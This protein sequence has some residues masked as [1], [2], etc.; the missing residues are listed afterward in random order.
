MSDHQLDALRNKISQS[1]II[2]EEIFELYK[3]ITRNEAFVQIEQQLYEVNKAITNLESANTS[4]PDALREI[5]NQMTNN[6]VIKTEADKA[7][8][9]YRAYLSELFR[10]IFTANKG[11]PK[12]SYSKL[13]EAESLEVALDTFALVILQKIKFSK[14]I[15]NIAKK[16]SISATAVR[17]KC[18]RF[19]GINL[20][21]LRLY[22]SSNHQ[23][24]FNHLLKT[25][26]QYEVQIKNKLGI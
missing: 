5:K 1:H 25:F 6:L 18:S 20:G 21:T 16:H 7:L 2:I 19:V 10:V 24:L 26:P 15:T 11:N 8:S 4:V 14:A 23:A 12:H 17:N 9:E 13:D 3:V 22:L